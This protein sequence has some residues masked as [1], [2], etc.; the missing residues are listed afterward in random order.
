MGDPPFGGPM[1]TALLLLAPAVL[2][3]GVSTHTLPH[4]QPAVPQTE[5]ADPDLQRP[6]AWLIEAQNP[7]GS[8]GETMKSPSPDVATTA[9]AGLALVRM[10]HTGSHGEH[11]DNTRRAV[12]FV[13][14]AV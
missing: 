13:V 4:G 6:L 10:G 1:R 14:A 3:A 8:W 7:D 9:I 5:R 2:A 11:Q 12:R